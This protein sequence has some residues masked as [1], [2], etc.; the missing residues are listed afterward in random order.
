MPVRRKKHEYI[1][2]EPVPP[3]KEKIK[4]SF[5]IEGEWDF[6]HDLT[7]DDFNGDS[8]LVHTNKETFK[9]AFFSMF[10]SRLYERVENMIENVKFVSLEHSPEVEESFQNMRKVLTMRERTRA[11]AAL[12]KAESEA[13]TLRK[14][15]GSNN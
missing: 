8:L 9:Q 13:A 6:N 5:V 2:P 11:E 10:S 15:L 7:A 3:G 4:F 14:K 12:A 1:G